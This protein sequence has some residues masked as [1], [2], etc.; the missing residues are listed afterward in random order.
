MNTLPKE[1]VSNI[2]SFAG[3]KYIDFTASEEVAEIECLMT[4]ETRSYRVQDGS[5]RRLNLVD[6]LR[7]AA[8][9]RS[10]VVLVNAIRFG[11]S[12]SVDR[13]TARNMY[14]ADTDCYMVVKNNGRFAV[15]NS[16]TLGAMSLYSNQREHAEISRRRVKNLRLS[17]TDLSFPEHS[18][19]LHVARE[20]ALESLRMLERMEH[21]VRLHSFENATV[22]SLIVCSF[23]YCCH[24][25][26]LSFQD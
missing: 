18:R 21:H 1:V 15:V 13:L 10:S 5:L 14:N 24:L 2:S 17:R 8:V 22:S 12:S 11:I 25:D 26:L 6:G 4:G 20:S 23:G 7:A 9:L 16:S 19:L 3:E